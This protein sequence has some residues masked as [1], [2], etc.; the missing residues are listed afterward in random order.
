V[1]SEG[2]YKNYVTPTKTLTIT[3]KMGQYRSSLQ[4]LV[5]TLCAILFMTGCARTLLPSPEAAFREVSPPELS[6]DLGLVGLA[7]AIEAQRAVLAKTSSR[8]M[9]FGPVTTTRKA[10]LEKLEQLLVVLKSSEPVDQK[11][12]FIR[13]NFRAVRRKTLGRGSADQLL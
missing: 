9:Q 12:T 7:D 2:A 1:E 5:S 6:D 8:T 10:Y 3:G 4:R 13:D 11:L